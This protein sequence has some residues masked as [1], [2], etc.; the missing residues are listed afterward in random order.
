MPLKLYLS[1]YTTNT[2]RQCKKLNK[3]YYYSC[4]YNLILYLHIRVYKSFSFFTI[5]VISVEIISTIFGGL[6]CLGL[7]K[8]GVR[9][10]AYIFDTNRIQN[11]Q[12]T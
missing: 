4:C 1:Y 3:K 9:D 5:V 8:K 7:E 11:I 6:I 2:K 10:C 12:C